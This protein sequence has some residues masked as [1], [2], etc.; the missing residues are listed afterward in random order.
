MNGFELMKAVQLH[1]YGGVDQLR[2]EDVPDP[3]PGPDEVLVKVAATSVNP[4]DWK[5]RRGDLKDRMPLHFPVILGRDVAGEVVEAGAN[6]NSWKRG[7]KVMGLV[8]RAYAEFLT[9]AADVLTPTPEG[10]DDRQAGAVPLV[11]TTGAQLIDQVRPERGATVLVT[12]AFGNV[13]RTAVYVARQRG[14]RVIAGVRASQKDRAASLGAD[15]VIATDSDQEIE[16]LPPLDAI[17][18]TVG[19]GLIEKL[20]EKLKPGGTLGS[21]LGKPRA[22]EGRDIRVEAVLAHPDPE[23]LRRLA[24]AVRDHQLEIPVARTFSLK[25]AGEAQALAERGNVD[26]KIVLV[27]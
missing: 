13:G 21:V 5:I 7:Q 1:G 12:G 6:V 3:K 8:N 16:S 18:D 11:A 27:P 26:G 14:A 20:I 23:L 15:Q 4:I 22:A 24:E 9:A 17:A 2:Y 19:Q 10:L 25:E